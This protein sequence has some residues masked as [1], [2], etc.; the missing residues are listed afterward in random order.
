MLFLKF[1]I[2]LLLLPACWVSIETFFLLFKEEALAGAFYN[3]PEFFFFSA[4]AFAC[5][6]VFLI[7]RENKILLWLY[8]AGHELTHALFALVFRGR[9]R[10]IHISP[11]GGHIISDTNNFVISLSPYFFPFYTIL[12]VPVWMLLDRQIFQFE[13]NAVFSLYALIG[14]TW[15]Y[16]IAYTVKMLRRKQTDVDYNGKLF[17]FAVI[18]LVNIL[19]ISLLL[20][21]ASPGTTFRDFGTLWLANFDSFGARFRESIGEIFRFVR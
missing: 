11:D 20:V 10:K 6:L 5:G 12:L 3:S 15:M 7:A 8:V 9:V 13:G 17:S 19:V 16:H 2:G 21:I 4:G 14:F 1:I 18:L